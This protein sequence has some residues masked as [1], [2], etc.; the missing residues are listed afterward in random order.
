VNEVFGPVPV[1]RCVRH[2]E[3]NV[4]DH[5]PERDRPAVKTRLRKAWASENHQQAVDAL[6]LLAGELERSHPAQPRRCGRAAG[7]ADPDPPRYPRQAQDHAPEHEPDRV[8]D[9]HRPANEPQ[10]QALAVRRHVPQM[11]RRRDARGRDTVPQDH[12]LQ[13]PR[14]ARPRRRT[15]SRRTA[16]AD[17]HHEQG[18][19][20]TPVT[21]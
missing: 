1:Q 19:S 8:D 13:R 3:R 11:D 6:Q 16:P 7:D 21:V 14:K 15:R 10:R 18:D 4:L 17:S 2:K 5:L 20:R 9:R 12:G